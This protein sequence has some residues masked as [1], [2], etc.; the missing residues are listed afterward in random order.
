MPL[1]SNTFSCMEGGSQL[2]V[3]QNNLTCLGG[4]EENVSDKENSTGP[5]VI[6]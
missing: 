6:Y 1:G 4:Q 3:I 5:P 2:R